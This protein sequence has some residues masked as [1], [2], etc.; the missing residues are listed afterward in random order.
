MNEHQP[1]RASNLCV[2]PRMRYRIECH[3]AG[4]RM[5]YVQGMTTSFDA[6]LEQRFSRRALLGTAGT[7][8]AATAGSPFSS[9]AGASAK[10]SPS[11]FKAVTPQS[12]DAVVLPKDYTFD[13]VVRW[14]DSLFAGTPSITR[15][16]LLQGGLLSTGAEERQQRQFG[17]NCDAIAYFP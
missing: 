2:K 4:T 5:W 17:A 7:L 13:L 1:R 12:T 10:E 6:V 15:Q 14:G 11:D 9:V 8:L 16:T 3:P